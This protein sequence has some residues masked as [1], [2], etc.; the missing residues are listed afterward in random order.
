MERLK[1]TQAPQ[2]CFN[3]ENGKVEWGITSAKEHLPDC[4]MYPEEKAGVV[5]KSG[6]KPRMMGIV[7][8]NGNYIQAPFCE[9]GRKMYNAICRGERH[10]Q[11]TGTNK[12]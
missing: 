1:R 10:R 2:G 9:K 4:T 5:D 8:E 11:K 3:F 12:K 6:G 7:D